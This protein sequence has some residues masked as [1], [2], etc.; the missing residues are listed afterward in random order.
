MRNGLSKQQD[1]NERL[2]NVE[3]EF[4]QY[5]YEQKNMP[6]EWQQK[7]EE[8]QEGQMRTQQELKGALDE[9]EKERAERLKNVEKLAAERVERNKELNEHM[10][11]DQSHQS[12]AS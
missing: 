1:E 6:N 12:D 7:A 8:L 5:K 9:L 10:K 2:V 3:F 4:A 11:R